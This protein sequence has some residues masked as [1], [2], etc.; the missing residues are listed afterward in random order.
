LRQQLNRVIYRVTAFNDR[1]EVFLEFT[2]LN[3]SKVTFTFFE[4]I[5]FSLSESLPVGGEFHFE[6]VD[7]CLFS[8]TERLA[9]IRA[10]QRLCG[11]IRC[12]ATASVTEV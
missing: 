2:Q 3:A 12:R 7:R 6:L 8:G 11:C 1:F 10:A 9:V 4:D 5:L